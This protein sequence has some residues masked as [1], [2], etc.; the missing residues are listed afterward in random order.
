MMQADFEF[1]LHIRKHVA[2]P[3]DLFVCGSGPVVE[4]TARPLDGPEGRCIGNAGNDIGTTHPGCW[5]WRPW[6]GPVQAIV[7]APRT[8]HMDG[9]AELKAFVPGLWRPMGLT[10]TVPYSGLQ[11]TAHVWLK[12]GYG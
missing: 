10:R 11:R 9:I 3:H 6:R 5:A 2:S 7:R 8:V 4:C 12:W 1:D